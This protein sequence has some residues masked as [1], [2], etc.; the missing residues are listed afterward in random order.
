[1]RAII[2]NPDKNLP[3]QKKAVT[4]V[5]NTGQKTTGMLKI[6]DNF[7]LT[8][9]TLD[10]SFRSFQKSDLTHVD[11]GSHSLMPAS[12]LGSTEVDDLISYLLQIGNQNA[13]NTPAHSSRSDDDDN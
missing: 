11:L 4:V 2:L 5:T 1:M 12:T 7:S 8:L 13:T 3:V 6:N 9:Q 10:G